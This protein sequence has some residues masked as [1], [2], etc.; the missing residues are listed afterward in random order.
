MPRELENVAL[1]A[2]GKPLEELPRYSGV[3]RF[4][5][6]GG[7]LLYIGKSIDIRARISAH[8]QEG[9][10]P[11]RHQRIMG[12]VE[13]I[14]CTATA[15]E[16]GALL[17]ENA[18]IKAETPLYNRRQRRVKKLWTIHLSR[19]DDGFLQPVAADFLMDSDRT[20]DSY[21][22][23]TISAISIPPCAVTRG[24]TASACAAWEWI[25]DAARASSISWVAATVP[26]PGMRA[27]MNTMRVCCLY[28]T[29]TG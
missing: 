24:I 6:A 13:Q 12:Q 14:D 9:R 26:A 19:S 11:G 22:L 7:A 16:V 5:D 27:A 4:Y 21:G 20:R 29:G 10:K 1:T 15:G 28:W 18:A 17:M 8:Y 3:Y 23:I 2:A 25:G